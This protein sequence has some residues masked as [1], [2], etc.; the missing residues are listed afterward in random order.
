MGRGAAPCKP[1][2]SLS[3]APRAGRG[4]GAMWVLKALGWRSRPAYRKDPG[5][6]N[7]TSSRGLGHLD[8]H[9]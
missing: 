6:S 7:L 9:N 5:I 4:S 8:F 2:Q 1:Q 3:L